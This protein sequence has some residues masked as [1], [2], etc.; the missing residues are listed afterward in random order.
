MATKKSTPA[1]KAASKTASRG[2]ARGSSGSGNA[3][4]DSSR[5]RS[6][7]TR[8]RSN[9]ARTSSG[10]AKSSGGSARSASASK[11]SSAGSARATSSSASA[12]RT[13]SRRAEQRVLVDHDEIRQWA[14]DRG[15]EPA[16]V[17]GTGGK[18][19]IGM[20]RLD[21]PGYSGESSLEH[22]SW[23]EW[24]PKF[25]EKNLA[26]IVEERTARGQVSNFNK[27]V[28]RDSVTTEERPR[29][30]AAGSGS[31]SSGGQTRAAGKSR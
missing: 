25:D 26:L 5:S 16:C 2:S 15:A 14:E 8:S 19:D 13:S 20:L 28:S 1:K 10:S 6:A 24:F 30:R 31:S 23:D 12:K 22:I 9:S 7:S 21:F 27:L 3:K 17:R 4:S 11:R 29:T 18:N